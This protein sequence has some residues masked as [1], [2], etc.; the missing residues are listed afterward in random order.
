[1]NTYLSLLPDNIS[2]LSTSELRDIIEENVPQYWKTKYENANLNLETIAEITGYFTRLED[3][4]SKREKLPYKPN[5]DT[6]KISKTEKDRVKTRGNIKGDNRPTDKNPSKYCTFHNSTTHDTHECKAKK[7]HDT[8]SNSEN[9]QEV[10]VIT[11]LPDNFCYEVY[12][13]KEV[14]SS[15]N[16]FKN[17]RYDDLFLS[18][19]Y[20]HEEANV[21]AVQEGNIKTSNDIDSTSTPHK[22]PAIKEMTT[23][24]L[25]TLMSKETGEKQMVNCL[26]DTGCSRGLICETLVLPKERLNQN[27]MNWKTKKGNFITSVSAEKTYFIPAFTT[28]LKVTSTFEIMP[29]S[30][31]EDSYKVIMGRNIIISL[32]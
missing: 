4:D 23:E 26:I 15:Q 31:S 2:P 7:N 27:T 25:L 8:K 28:N 13:T 16:P 20:H 10:N 1:L 32:G 29:A 21:M 14:P 3:L 18:D 22:A 11:P 12:S 24:I 5:K 30:M 17:V 19:N 6:D 9:N